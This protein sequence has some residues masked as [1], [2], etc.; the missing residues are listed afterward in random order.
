MN[1]ILRKELLKH[2]QN[3][4]LRYI[5]VRTKNSQILSHCNSI[6][7]RAKL[8]NIHYANDALILKYDYEY[9]K[10]Q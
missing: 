4:E 8:R 6:I 7:K 1:S 2:L 9:N 5:I 3:K 10:T